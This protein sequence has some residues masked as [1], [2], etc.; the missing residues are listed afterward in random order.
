[1]WASER[2][3]AA[4]D[5]AIPP[6]EGASF[7]GWIDGAD[8]RRTPGGAP[9][10]PGGYHTFEHRWALADAFRFHLDIGKDAVHERTTTQA[11]QLKDG[12]RRDRGRASRHA[13]GPGAQQ[14]HRVRRDPG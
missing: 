14:R 11:T 12:A 1:M 9:F 7:E 10:T 8:P 4:I 2:A 5:P 13:D 6:F 3:W